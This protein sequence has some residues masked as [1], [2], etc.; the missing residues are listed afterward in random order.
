MK[1]EKGYHEFEVVEQD[2]I[3]NKKNPKRIEITVKA[4]INGETKTQDFPFGP[5]QVA[6]GR[7]E[8]H[9]VSWIEDQEGEL[10]IPDLKGEKIQ[11]SGYDFTGPERDYPGSKAKDRK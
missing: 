3:P 11:N 9:V 6:D 5:K 10:E 7:W 1:N 4:N 8:K 2:F